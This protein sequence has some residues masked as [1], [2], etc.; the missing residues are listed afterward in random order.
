M[1]ILSNI[2]FSIS[3]LG[4]IGVIINRLH[5]LSIL[6][7]LELIMISIF[8]NICIWSK[9]YNNPLFLNFPIILITLSACEASAGLALMVLISRSHN[10]DL[11]ANIN[12]LQT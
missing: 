12:L 2:L 3:I 10:T 8:L 6:L 7:C 9:N 5:L 4:I 1:H 11:L